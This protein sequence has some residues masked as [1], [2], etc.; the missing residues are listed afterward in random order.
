MSLV[1][2]LFSMR[3]GEAVKRITQEQKAESVRV[4]AR[5]A[6]EMRSLIAARLRGDAS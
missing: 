3:E 5:L 2:C 4:E 6:A 1:D